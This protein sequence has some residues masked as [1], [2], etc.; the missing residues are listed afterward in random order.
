MTE[1]QK[2]HRINKIEQDEQDQDDAKGNDFDFLLI[3]SIF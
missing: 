3:L 2:I 1:G